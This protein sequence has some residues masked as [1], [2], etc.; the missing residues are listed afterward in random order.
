MNVHGSAGYFRRSGL[1][2]VPPFIVHSSERA[3]NLDYTP[4]ACAIGKVNPLLAQKRYHSLSSSN[5]AYYAIIIMLE[6]AI[7]YSVA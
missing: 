1:I 7:Y 2:W 6:L 5:V 3:N 4:Y